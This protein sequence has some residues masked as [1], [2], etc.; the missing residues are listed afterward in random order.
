ML[1]PYFYGPIDDGFGP[2]TEGFIRD[3]FEATW[4]LD[5]WLTLFECR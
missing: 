5:A 4:N 3:D 2:V 1:P